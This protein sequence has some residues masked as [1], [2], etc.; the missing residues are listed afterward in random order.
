MAGPQPSAE[1]GQQPTLRRHR[2][3]LQAASTTIQG[4]YGYAHANPRM[5]SATSFPNAEGRETAPMKD[6][7]TRQILPSVTRPL[8]L[9]QSGAATVGSSTPRHEN[10]CARDPRCGSDTAIHVDGLAA[11]EGCEVAGEEDCDTGYSGRPSEPAEGDRV[12]DPAAGL[13]RHG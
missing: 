7:P 11:D 8:A 6:G 2:H 5:G 12:L 4:Y 10:A 1:I 9:P 3:L 13:G